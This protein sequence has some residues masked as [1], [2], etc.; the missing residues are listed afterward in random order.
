MLFLLLLIHNIVDIPF[1]NFINS[2]LPYY[3]KGYHDGDALRVGAETRL[4]SV[5]AQWSTSIQQLHAGAFQVCCNALNNCATDSLNPHLLVLPYQGTQI[6]FR[7]QQ[8]EY[9]CLGL[10]YNI[11]NREKFNIFIYLVK[12]IFLDLT[13]F[14]NDFTML[15]YQETMEPQRHSFTISFFLTLDSLQSVLTGPLKQGSADNHS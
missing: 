14:L 6:F 11:T 7:K 5:F 9:K 12:T 1:F 3:L 8:T 4:T 15:Q 2:C 10:S 13:A